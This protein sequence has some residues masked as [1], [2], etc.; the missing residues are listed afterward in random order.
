MKNGMFV[1]DMRATLVG[2]ELRRWAGDCSP[3][4]TLDPKVHNL[5]MK[6]PQTLYG[7]ER[8]NL[9]SGVQHLKK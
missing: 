4:Y 2:Y 1:L 8:A 9:A 6:N 7:F 5:V 3:E